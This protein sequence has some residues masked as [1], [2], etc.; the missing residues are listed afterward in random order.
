MRTLTGGSAYFNQAIQPR[1][2]VR[3]FDGATDILVQ[4]TE[5]NGTYPDRIASFDNITSEIDPA[6]GMS[7]VSGGG[8][9]RLTLD[10]D[11]TLCTTASL[12]P[13]PQ[14]AYAGAGRLI[15]TGSS[16]GAYADTRN[17]TAC[18]DFG[19]PAISVGRIY[20]AG[21]DWFTVIRAFVQFKV[22]AGM[23]SCDDAYI[24]LVGSEN[25]ADTAFTIQGVAGTW[26]NLSSTTGL[27]NDFTGWAA[28]GTYSVTNLLE[29]WTTAEYDA[30]ATYLRFNAAG[31]A[32][33]LAATGSTFRMILIS[34]LDTTI[35]A[36]PSGNEYV[37]FEQ[38]SAR[39]ALRY[40]SVT[41]DN[42][43]VEI[44]LGFDPVTT[45]NST[46]LDVVTTQIVDT[47]RLDGRELDM[48]FRANDFKENPTIP[49]TVI[50]LTDWPNCP[51]NN[52]G[53]TVPVVYGSFAL[54]GEHRSG[55]GNYQC[56]TPG[57]TGVGAGN[58]SYPD[59][60]R[61]IVVKD[62]DGLKTVLFTGLR[63]K[64]Y[65]TANFLFTWNSGIK[66]FDAFAV[67]ALPTYNASIGHYTDIHAP[68]VNDQLIEVF[69]EGKY[70]S[71]STII[72][73]G[74]DAFGATDPEKAY[75]TDSDTYA[76]MDTNTGYI[77][78][79]FAQ[80]SGISGETVVAYVVYAEFTGG[81]DPTKLK[82]QI[83][84]D[85]RD[86]T[87]D[88][89]NWVLVND[90]AP[91][92]TDGQ[93]QYSFFDVDDGVL[94]FRRR[95]VQVGQYKLRLYKDTAT[96]TARIYDVCSLVAHDTNEITEVYTNCDGQQ[97][98][99]SGT[100]TGTA[101]ALIENP[102][103]VIEA[104]ARNEMSLATADIDTAA[105]D[106]AATAVTGCKF[107]FQL[108]DRKDARDILDGLGKQAR[109]FLRWNES[110]KLTIKKI[111][112]ADYFGNSG[113]DVPGAHD[114]FTTTGDPVS[115][116][117]AHHQLLSDVRIELSD[118]DDH[119][120]TFVLK[121]R[122][123]Y[124]TGDYAAVLTCDK[125]AENL[126]DTKLSGT[127]G[128]TLVAL[129]SAAY[130]RSGKVNTLEFECPYIRDE[131]TATLLMQHLIEWYSVRRY[132][133]E[134]TAGISALCFVEGDFINV[135]TDTI[136]NL[137][138]TAV[139][140]RKKWLVKRRSVSLND[141]TITFTAIEV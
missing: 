34:S 5:A 48:T 44:L 139:M 36:G 97:D 96:G 57:G 61:G 31:R 137:F 50:T 93:K 129:C 19:T 104:L 39:L 68:D 47:W 54:T 121:Y 110:D 1:V 73:T 25:G 84:R 35:N 6:G 53:K 103:H 116:V 63:L 32:A 136:E 46:A 29:T 41:L 128:T 125:D 112:S 106:T 141:M 95:P 10:E 24:A 22:P 30:T 76:V 45:I 18:T 71:V 83:Y 49:A 94:T 135:R 133:L 28:S 134:F 20:S 14:S 105:F 86:E 26:S 131:T 107:A 89:L 91:W 88:A 66:A 9:K 77:D 100:V 11:F 70:R 102:A 80:P 7:T 65:S 13:E 16:G 120:T 78:F 114:I 79:Y 140:N 15:C 101:S 111:S 69:A 87:T 17:A 113:T 23:T 40:N 72:P 123:N 85:E 21:G 33:I 115:G 12:E 37:T 2:F 108:N 52:V 4:G 43:D 130:S 90:L 51:E 59:P 122:Q 8:V 138:G 82:F 126:D 124:A 60:I 81:M 119:C 118:A 55:T 42:K 109:T 74:N 27:F 117:F 127:T 132:T 98:D 62:V 64:G 56:Y 3:V 58:I 38:S 67:H 92:T 75:D 99:G